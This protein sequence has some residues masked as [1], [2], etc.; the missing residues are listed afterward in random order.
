MNPCNHEMQM[1]L[2]DDQAPPMA[3]FAPGQ[4]CV[5]RR[6]GVRGPAE[7]SPQGFSLI[8]LLVVVAILAML[9]AIMIPAF[10]S[11][12][13]AG[14]LSKAASDISGLLEQARTYA[15]G[16]N[17][18]VYV[19]L[20]EV[21][22]ITPTSADGV[23]R[24]AVAV[25]ASQ[26]GARPYTN[27]PAPLTTNITAISKLQYF[28]NVHLTSASALNNG[29]NMTGRPAADID[30]GGTMAKTSFKWPIPSGNKYIFQRVI[31][32]DPQGVPRVQTNSTFDSS[33]NGRI[34]IALLPTHGN[35]SSTNANQAAI[36]I[37]GITGAV[38]VFRP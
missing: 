32:F 33:V 21:D 18:Y 29:T 36:Q 37:D 16:K 4:S 27:S 38:R 20:Q 6:T 3:G 26:D 14:M 15:M 11:T 5:R 31:E 24:V 25:V 30:L 23:G 22:V 12:G 9:S 1:C 10:T 8:E 2:G 17:T 34:E 7:G 13:Q 35:V 28:D 19:G